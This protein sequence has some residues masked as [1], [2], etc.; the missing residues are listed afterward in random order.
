MNPT[1]FTK[2]DFHLGDNLIFLHLLRALAKQRPGQRFVHFCHACH[3]VQLQ[4][5]VDDLP[6][7]ILQSF[8]SPYWEKHH[9]DA[10]DTW[11]NSDGAWESSPLRWDWSA[12]T[13]WHHGV[14]ARKLGFHPPFTCREHLLLDYPALEK[15]VWSDHHLLNLNYD[16]LVVNSEPCSGQFSPMAQHGS[17]YLNPLI[18]KLTEK[19]TVITTSPTTFCD[20]TDKVSENGLSVSEI[21]S[22]SRRC[23]HVIG[24][25]T[26]PFWACLNTHR[27][28]YH[29]GQRTVALLNNGENLNLPFVEQRASVEEL[30]TIAK[31][32]GWI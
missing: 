32:E 2:N 22:L 24:V 25:M 11:K 16:V 30:F 10:I 27:H 23:H 21:G 29:E 18:E 5:V 19:M 3:H 8:E 20:S 13:L 15:D 9:K 31:L 28:H 26:G 6:E 14:I 17:G 1:L 4:E 12:Y 7:I